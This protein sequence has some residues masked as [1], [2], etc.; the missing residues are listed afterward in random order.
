MTGRGT[1]AGDRFR[2]DVLQVAF[3]RSPHAHALIER[4][5]QSAALSAPGVT[6]IFTA[7][8]LVGLPIPAVRFAGVPAGA[9]VLNLAAGELLASGK[10]VCVGQ[11]VAAT[12]A[13]NAAL[14]RD[15]ADLIAV[16]YKPLPAVIDVR[17]AMRSSAAVVH[18]GLAT[19]VAFRFTIGAQDAE[20]FFAEADSVVRVQ[21]TSPRLA[22][23]P[24][25]PRTI[26][27]E[28][29]PSNDGLIV[30]L[31]TQVPHGVRQALSQMLG[32][33][34]A[35]IAVKVG[36]VGGGFGAKA[37]AYAEEAVV[38]YLAWRLRASVG[39][40]ET[41]SENLQ[42]MIQGRGQQ[43][44]I[45]LGVTRHGA[46]TGLRIATVI[47]M[48]SFVQPFAAGPA[49]NAAMLG[50]G[51]YQIPKVCVSV[52]GVYTNKVP[53]A[54]YRGSGRPEAAYSLERAVSAAAQAIGMDPAELH[55]RNFIPAD[56]FPYRTVTGMTYD[57][58]NYAAAF[59]KALEI[60]DYEGWRRKQR[61]AP[62]KPR[63]IG[64]GIASF[65]EFSGPQLLEHAEVRVSGDGKVVMLSGA[66]AH[67]QGH[68]TTFAQVIADEF[69]VAMDA[70][71]VLEGDTT[72]IP[73]GIGTFG[74]RS[75]ALAGS[76]GLMAAR[77]VKDILLH[78]AAD[79]LEARTE[80]VELRNARFTVVGVPGPG[81]TFAEVAAAAVRGS[82]GRQAGKETWTGARETFESPGLTFPFGTH[83][84]VVEVDSESGGVEILDYVA[85]DDCGNMINPLL[86]DGQV[87]GGIVQ[88][89]GQAL[90][91]EV[92]YDDSVQLLTGSLMD[93]AIPR[94]AHVPRLKLAHTV[95]PSPL[96]PLGAK[97]VGEAGATASPAAIF[98][99]VLDAVAPLGVT[100]LDMPLTAPKIW[101][102]I[103]QARGR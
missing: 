3:L 16:D 10:V 64:I 68:E 59:E 86:V 39:W 101:M 51:P 79:L 43:S 13:R 92:I 70:V 20:D 45:E 47:D 41:R 18:D 36:D 57:S 42:S 71:D 65:V 58:G 48:G 50:P 94:A 17:D 52:T 63:S 89:L 30:S 40:T 77:H 83:V 19:N 35:N 62:R 75:A 46:I 15:A 73:T 87:V 12:V 98:N 60:V 33:P 21:A 53:T 32:I 82:G 80:D 34:D 88:G 95:T 6:A 76:A 55:R 67:G 96:N 54:P 31:S 74:S 100:E 8:D 93:Y 56:A 25:E 78:A 69:G 1:F 28:Y 23:I 9:S 22:A 26:V 81:L 72:A 85:V 24:L 37:F 27:A 84:A 61:A 44:E 90:M 5:D 2:A 97:G 49:N 14:A 38:A 7:T 91:E 103:Q 99:A 4:L 66:S 11:P 29:D 102:A